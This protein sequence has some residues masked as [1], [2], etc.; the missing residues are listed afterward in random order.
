MVELL[1]RHMPSFLKS[2][3]QKTQERRERKEEAVRQY[4]QELANSTHKKLRY[5]ALSF[6]LSRLYLFLIRLVCGIILL[7]SSLVFLR[8]SL[9]E[10]YSLSI[11]AI[12]G[13]FFFLSLLCLIPPFFP[14]RLKQLKAL[15]LRSQGKFQV[16]LI[17]FVA[18]NLTLKTVWVFWDFFV[19][20]MGG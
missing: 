15:F 7:I 3:I 13:G 20:G 8:A 9:N 10:F 6:I 4:L 2:F 12:G 1:S 11:G 17:L 5:K 19:K 18:L 16:I 14:S